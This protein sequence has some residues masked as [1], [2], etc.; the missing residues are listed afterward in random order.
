MDWC[1]E[2]V[3]VRLFEYFYFDIFQFVDECC[4]FIFR[5]LELQGYIGFFWESFQ[6]DG[7]VCDSQG[8]FG[9]IYYLQYF[10]IF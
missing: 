8:G 6:V 9:Y 2:E 4:L 1:L 10:R 3:V 7:K 5:F